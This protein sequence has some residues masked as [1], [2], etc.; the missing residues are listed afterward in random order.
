M[1]TVSLFCIE[2]SYFPC[3]FSID[4]TKRVDIAFFSVFLISFFFYSFVSNSVSEN[5]LPI[6]LWRFQSSMLIP[7][8]IG[9]ISLL[10]VMC[11]TFCF[12]LFFFLQLMLN[13]FFLL[14][15]PN[16]IRVSVILL[17]VPWTLPS[18]IWRLSKLYGH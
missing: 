2:L 6:S 8:Q 4:K 17:N 15:P 11:W 13:S 16:L 14:F 12:V 7:A 10:C 9:W 5:S 18:L 1:A 3:A